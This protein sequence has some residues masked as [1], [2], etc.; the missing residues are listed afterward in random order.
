[1]DIDGNKLISNTFSNGRFHS[2]WL[3][4]IYTRLKLARNLLSENGVIFVSIGNDE[5]DN[6]KKV[7]NEIF[8][9]KNYISQ[10]VWTNNEGG[11]SSDSKFFKIKHEYI[12][13]YAKNVEKTVEIK[14]I[15]IEDLG[16]YKLSDKYVSTRGKY[17]LVKLA[18]AS[19]QYSDSLNYS[20]KAPDGT[21]VYPSDNTD[22][23]KAIWR[24][25]KEKLKWGF[26]N[27][28]L[29]WKKDKNNIWQ[30]Y[31]KQYINCDKD[32]NIVERTKTPLGLIDRYSSTQGSKEL[33]NLFKYRTFG[34]PKP[35]GLLRYLIERFSYEDGDII[36]DFFSGSASTAEAVSKINLSDNIRR[37]ILWYKYQKNVIKILKRLKK[38]IKQYV[39]L[40]KKELKDL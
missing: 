13:C 28:F 30:L 40:A 10:L 21:I 17:Q 18:S 27:E 38:A 3:S 8:G 34:Y 15:Y 14:N 39:I 19:L 1:M 25:G 12:L 26:E 33:F 11:G 31:S 16:R 4:M 24:W 35:T 5:V 7:L 22:K 2:D 29:E 32:G 37:N 20:I 9:E 36:L 23:E 6:M